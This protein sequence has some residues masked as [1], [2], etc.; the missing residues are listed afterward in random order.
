M[1]YLKENYKYFPKH[2][3]MHSSAL[4]FFLPK[5]VFLSFNFVMDK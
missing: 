4:P 2:S 5:G 3:A 1:F